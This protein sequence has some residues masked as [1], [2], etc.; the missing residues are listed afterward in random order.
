MIRAK[1]LLAAILGA[2]LLLSA[3]SGGD[4]GATA[5]DSGSSEPASAAESADGNEPAGEAPAAADTSWEGLAQSEGLS[6]SITYMHS[7]DDYERQMYA[8]MFA[9]YMELVPGVTVEQMFTPSDYEI[10]LQTLAASNTLPDI[11]WISESRM[12][13]Y[14]SAGHLE[15]LT[16]YLAQYPALHGDMLPGLAEY[17]EYNGAPYAMTKDWTS[18]VMYI[19]K[20][21]FSDMDV[22][23]PTSDWTMEDYREIAKQ[24]TK[25]D[26]ERVTHYGT[27][28]NN[29]R[30]DWVNFMGNYDAQ[31]FKDGKANV[32]DPDALKGIRVG[33]DIIQDGSAPSP[34]SVAASENGTEDRLFII[35]RVAMYPS[36]RWMVPAFRQEVD[37][38]WT[39]I[40]MPKG[41]TRI[42]PLIS[43]MVGISS[44]GSNKEIAANL[45]S[46]QMSDEGL[47][48]VMDSA[49]AMPPYQH[50]MVNEAYVNT[51]PETDAFIATSQYI[52]HAPQSEIL[53]TGKWAQFNEIM[54]AELSLAYESGQ[55]IEEAVA[56]IDAKANSE[57]FTG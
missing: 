30:A 2:M 10:K 33:Y 45:V 50:L 14:A 7:G 48:F 6:G 43:S 4:S 16:P 29:Y 1:R 26:G 35:G 15:D 53:K 21:I 52:G 49:L 20:E 3:C 51:P 57:V 24:L 17:G 32:S 27:A 41:T 25:V 8:D 11:Y 39:A 22:K 44:G 56:N 9:R 42:C 40:E 13:E 28:V 19:N 38:E 31:W 34:G 12:A 46:Y 5:T 36:G 18:Y 37:F 55:T 23:I 47:L 54:K